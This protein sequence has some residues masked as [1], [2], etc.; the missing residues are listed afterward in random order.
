MTLHV[1][2]SPAL[3]RRPTDTEV[4]AAKSVESQVTKLRMDVFAFV[5]SRGDWGATG[6]E[7]YSRTGIW[8]YTVKPRLT[9]LKKLDL[10]VDNA[11]RRKN[12]NGRDEI[13]YVLTRTGTVLAQKQG[14]I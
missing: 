8:I 11:Q 3:H 13:V 7:I 4:A 9:E 12:G 1:T 10:I 2:N 14:F 5:A 6:W